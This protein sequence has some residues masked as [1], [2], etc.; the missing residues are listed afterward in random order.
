MATG[1]MNK[2]IKEKKIHK[3]SNGEREKNKSCSKGG[4]KWEAERMNGRL[5]AAADYRWDILM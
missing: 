5:K 4:K 2:D 1:R 3:E